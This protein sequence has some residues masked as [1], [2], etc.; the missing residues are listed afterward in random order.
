MRGDEQHILRKVFRADIP[1][2]KEERTTENKMERCS[3]VIQ[4]DLIES[5]R[6]VG[7]GDMETEYDQSYRRPNND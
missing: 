3:D 2:E 6:G 4:R 5:E 7:Q 1:L